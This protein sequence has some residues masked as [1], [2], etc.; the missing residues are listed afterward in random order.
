MADEDEFEFWEEWD[1]ADAPSRPLRFLPPGKSLVEVTTRTIHGRFLMLP[2]CEA[3]AIIRGVLGRACH[4]Y[5]E[6][7]I[8]A[9]W[10]LSNH[11]EALLVVPNSAVLS[12]FMSHVNSNLARQLGALYDWKERFWGRRYRA[13]VVLGKEAQVRRLKYLLSQGTKE[14]LI[15]CP[16]QWPGVSSLRALLEGVNDIG[17][18][19]DAKAEYQSRKQRRKRGSAPRPREDFETEY[20]IT[21]WPLP[22]WEKLSSEECR[23]RARELVD[24][25][26]RLARGRRER[27]QKRPLGVA[28][29]LAQHPHDHPAQIAKSPAPLVHASSKAERKQFK[30]RYYRFVRRFRKAASRFCEGDLSAM[31]D[32]PR[33]CFLPRPPGEIRWARPRRA[34]A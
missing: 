3:N 23:E 19:F 17:T 34:S 22:C 33:G 9:Y 8:V 25:I 24:E 4:L 1:E 28:K 10:F 5:P 15:A 30:N 14:N 20:E 18:W 32:F 11:W 6:V 13:I 2:R 27:T 31:D 16:A 21:V 29:L 12:A 26:E 7:K